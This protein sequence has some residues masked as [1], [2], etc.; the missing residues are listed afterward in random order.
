MKK[1][2]FILLLQL[3]LINTVS[4][5]HSGRTDEH[6]GHYD[7]STG[8][9]H[10]HNGVYEGDY[11]APIEEGGTEINYDNIILPNTCPNCGASIDEANG[12]Y[13]FECAY[14]LVPE[15]IN[16]ISVVDGPA[17]KT[18]SEYYQ[19]VQQLNTQ[20]ENLKSQIKYKENS[21][22]ESNEELAKKKQEIEALNIKIV[23]MW[24]GFIFV[25]LLATYIAYNIGL[26]KLK[27]SQKSNN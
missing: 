10:Y 16:L 20:I 14:R 17:T 3:I 26:N 21:I 27:K 9:Y 4:L 23:I 7:T 15:N 2:I 13:C 5:A 22:G 18:R 24:I 8:Y 6:G 11:T 1:K 12:M 19:E 25:F